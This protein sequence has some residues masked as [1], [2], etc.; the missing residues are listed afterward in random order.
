MRLTSLHRQRGVGLLEVMVA[1]LLLAIGVLG[2]SALQVR[3]VSATSEGLSRTQAMSLMR[4]L[5]EGIRTNPT[6]LDQYKTSMNSGSVTVPSKNCIGNSSGTVPA[7]TPAELAVFESYQIT[8]MANNQGLSMNIVNCPG[9]AEPRQCILAAWG[10][11]TPTVGSDSAVN[12][13]KA[14]GVYHRQSTCLLL[15]A[16]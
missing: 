8:L 11:T 6:A 4:M 1:M 5:A 10:K 14:E 7:C 9:V 16:I 2:F 12:C 15:E 13:L 3:A